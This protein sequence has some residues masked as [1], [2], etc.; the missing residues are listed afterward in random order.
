MTE[1]FAMSQTDWVK[2]YAGMDSR[3]TLK[4]EQLPQGEQIGKRPEV[5]TCQ[6]KK[7]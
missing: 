1:N 4:Y 6:V 3:I 2:K 5:N 7:S